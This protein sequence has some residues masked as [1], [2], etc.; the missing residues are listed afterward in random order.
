M[1]AS[2]TPQASSDMAQTSN[3]TQNNTSETKKGT[4]TLTHTHTHT[5][6]FG[7]AQHNKPKFSLLFQTLLLCLMSAS[8]T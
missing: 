8:M 2:V 3:T 1:K 5:Y 6:W 7:L 4:S